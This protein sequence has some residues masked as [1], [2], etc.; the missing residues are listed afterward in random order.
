MTPTAPLNPSLEDSMLRE[1]SKIANAIRQ[2]VF[3]EL[4]FYCSAGIAHSKLFA[5]VA[6]SQNKPNKQTIVCNRSAKGS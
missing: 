6:C 4:H 2:A 5:K 3:A 1:A